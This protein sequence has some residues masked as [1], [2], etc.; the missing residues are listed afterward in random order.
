MATSKTNILYVADLPKEVNQD[1]IK[2]L[3]EKYHFQY[4]NLNNSKSS[5]VWAQVFLESGEYCTK[6]RHELNGTIIK[7][8]PIRICN[9]ENK[10]KGNYS[11]NNSKRSLLVRNI[12]QKM[13]QK[14]FYQIFLKYGDINSAKIEYDD[15]GNSK[16]FGY[17]S[18]INEDSDEKAKKNLNNVKFYDKSLDIVDLLPY[19]SNTLYSNTSLFASNFPSSFTENDI[20]K[21]FEKKYGDIKSVSIFKNKN[22]I[23]KGTG[24]ITFNTYESCAKCMED[25]NNNHISF[26]G[27]NQLSVIPAKTKEEFEK[28]KYKKNDSNQV[29]IQFSLFCPTAC[30]INDKMDLEKEIRLFIKVVLLEE[31]NPKDI[32]VDFNSFSGVVTF[33]RK[34]DIDIFLRKY[35]EFTSKNIPNFEC[36]PV[37]PIYV[38]N[39]N[40]DKSIDNVNQKASLDNINNISN[41]N[42]PQSN[43]QILSSFPNT[44][45]KINPGNNLLYNNNSCVGSNYNMQQPYMKGFFLQ[46]TQQPIIQIPNMQNP[47]F[48][49]PE[50]MQPKNQIMQPNMIMNQMMPMRLN[51]LTMRMPDNQYIQRGVPQ[52]INDKK[53]YKGKFDNYNNYY[54]NQYRNMPMY[55]QMFMQGMNGNQMQYKNPNDIQN[56][57]NINMYNNYMMNYHQQNIDDKD[58]PNEEVDQRNLENLNYAQLISQFNPNQPV[59]HYLNP[60]QCNIDENEDIANE[61]ADSIY[62]IAFKLHPK[63]ASKITGMIKE[64]GVHKMNMLLSKKDDLIELIEKGYE[65]IQQYNDTNS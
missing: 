29:K 65:M 46:Q 15:Q 53:Q 39:Q 12:D 50:Y 43:N 26:P 30:K 21:F 55:Q 63:E 35:T 42:L 9:F 56:Q 13:S 22:G 27:L 2:K 62:E 10:G 31:Y 11:D 7:G 1:D 52:G 19:K 33:N 24:I 14:E 41:S 44:V 6:A 38:N 28:K 40:I 45:P 36:F 58:R 54:M 64:K 8:K 32:E 59:Q 61:I 57:M 20:K 18:Y 23:S 60:E 48:M 49:N 25:L 47:Q 34:E 37:V 51:N 16:G 5:S 3:F 17:V 4:V